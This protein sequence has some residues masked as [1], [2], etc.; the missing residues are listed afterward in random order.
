M[1]KIEKILQVLSIF[2][3]RVY[4]LTWGAILPPRCRFFPSCS[5]YAIQTTKNVGF[6][7]GIPLILKRVLVC[8][9]LSG[10]SG[11]DLPPVGKTEKFKAK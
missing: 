5:S 7:K 9:P 4:Q 2:L 3:V 8:H 10:R 6:Y 11:V 1:E